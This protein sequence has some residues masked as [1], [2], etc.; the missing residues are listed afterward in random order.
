MSFVGVRLLFTD[1]IL[2]CAS[3]R[4]CRHYLQMEFKCHQSALR[5][6]FHTLKCTKIIFGSGSAPDPAGGAHSAPPDPLAEIRGGEGGKGTRGGEGW[7]GEGRGGE[8]RKA[9]E[10]REGRGKI[11]PPDFETWIRLCL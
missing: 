7:E 11:G 10:G 2:S 4:G 8:G 3:F 9:K 1:F 5:R 6:Q